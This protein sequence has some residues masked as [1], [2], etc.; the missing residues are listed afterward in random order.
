MGKNTNNRGC[1]NVSDDLARITNVSWIWFVRKLSCYLLS[2]DLQIIT[3]NWLTLQS[4][5]FSVHTNHLANGWDDNLP[6]RGCGTKSW[7]LADPCCDWGTGYNDGTLLKIFLRVQWKISA[8]VLLKVWSLTVVEK[9]R[10]YLKQTSELLPEVF[11]VPIHAPGPSEPPPAYSSTEKLW[12]SC[13]FMWY[14]NNY[15]VC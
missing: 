6:W 7:F 3:P 1:K 12:Y 15:C 4:S 11:T 14:I 10:R 9:A 13:A 8:H 2:T 5:K